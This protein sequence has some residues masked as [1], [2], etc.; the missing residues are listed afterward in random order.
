MA[1]N[2]FTEI[3]PFYVTDV[4]FV[5]RKEDIHLAWPS[6]RRSKTKTAE[7]FAVET[8]FFREACDLRGKGTGEIS[9]WK[10][11]NRNFT[12]RICTLKRFLGNNNHNQMYPVA[13]V[14]H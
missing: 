4:T 14:T 13:F 7:C 11:S 5:S 6:T 12:E 10:S 2:C 9:P 1:A 3:A 8:S